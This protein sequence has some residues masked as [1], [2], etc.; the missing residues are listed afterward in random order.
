MNQLKKCDI[1]NN[2]KTFVN[3]PTKDLKKYKNYFIKGQF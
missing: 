1:V 3:V 2:L